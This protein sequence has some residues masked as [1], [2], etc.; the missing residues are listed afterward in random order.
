MH[1]IAGQDL[2][3]EHI[4]SVKLWKGL[5]LEGIA[6]RDSLPYAEKYG[7]GPVDGLKDLFR[8]T[9]RCATFSSG[10]KTTS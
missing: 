1:Q 4:P 9:L 8:G 2:L 7:L 10:L 3:K 5:A 6:N